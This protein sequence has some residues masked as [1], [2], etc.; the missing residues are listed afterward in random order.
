MGL[1]NLKMKQ[2]TLFCSWMVDSLFLKETVCFK[3]NI[4]PVL[5]P[6]SHKDL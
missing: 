4:N 2:S 1:N 3:R 6:Y 5:G